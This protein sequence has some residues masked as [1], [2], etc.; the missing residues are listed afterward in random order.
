M[1]II[2]LIGQ[3]MRVPHLGGGWNANP[4]ETLDRFIQESPLKI[5]EGYKFDYHMRS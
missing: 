3:A 2:P 4:L 1:E 5:V